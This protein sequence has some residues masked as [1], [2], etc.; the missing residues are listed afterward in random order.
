MFFF[1]QYRKLQN[2]NKRK[3]Y[4]T[5]YIKVTGNKISLEHTTLRQGSKDKIKAAL[6]LPLTKKPIFYRKFKKFTRFATDTLTYLTLHK[7]TKES[8]YEESKHEKTLSLQNSWNPLI[9]KIIKN[10]INKGNEN[11]ET[12]NQSHLGQ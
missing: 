9:D 2:F 7:L 3:T 4:T 8:R 11:K 1:G 10:M 12:N 6:I 5:P